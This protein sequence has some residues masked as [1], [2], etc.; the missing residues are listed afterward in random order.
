MGQGSQLLYAM[1]DKYLH[2]S[3]LAVICNVD[4]QRKMYM[5]CFVG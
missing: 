2:E 1:A 4:V 5:Q 3:Y